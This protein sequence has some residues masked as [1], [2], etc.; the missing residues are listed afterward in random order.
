[1]VLVIAVVALVLGITF[2]QSLFGLFSGIVNLFCTIVAMVIAFAFLEPLNLFV[3]GQGIHQSFSEP[4]CFVGLYVLAQ[5][6][7]RYLADTF[8]RGNVRVPMYADWI[9]GA[10]CAFLNA[11]ITVG[12]LVIGFLMLPFGGRSMMFSRFERDSKGKTDAN[13]YVV[14]ERHNL[15]FLRPDDFTVGLFNIL[16]SG[17]LKG[18]SVTDEAHP[19]RAFASVYPDFTRWVFWTGNTVQP[20]TAT[21]PFR[22]DEGDGF[23]DGVGI[24]NWWEEPGPLMAQYCKTLPSYE[25]RNDLNFDAPAPYNV[26]SDKNLLGIRLVLKRAA[27]DRG[28]EGEGAAHRFRPTQIRLVGTLRGEP[29]EYTP[30]LIGGLPEN[31]DRRLTAPWRRVVDLDSDFTLSAA[32]ATIDAYFEVDPGFDPWFVEYR[33]HA[34]VE[35]RG[36]PEKTPP[37]PLGAG[38]AESADASVSAEPTG[39][40]RPSTGDR[41]GAT[42]GLQSINPDISGVSSQ[43]P[44]PIA[45]SAV[46]SA[47][48]DGS[49]LV[50]GR[51]AGS[52]SRVLAAEGA[53]RLE[54]FAV[55]DGQYLLQVNCTPFG[56]RSLLGQVFNFAGSV[57]SQYFAVDDRNNRYPLAG[58][59]GV[60]P[61]GGEPYI[62]LYYVGGPDTPEAMSFRGMLDFT[63]IKDELRRRPSEAQIG[64]LFHI[65]SRT[66]I[67]KIVNQNNAGIENIDFTA[68]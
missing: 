18:G 54:R 32:A 11:E 64:L 65:P 53:P 7:L 47:E 15:S 41:H 66:H 1:M 68:P 30:R 35:V 49:D 42:S 10:V 21:A 12:I 17:S 25:N 8:L 31:D 46:G 63:E 57:T 62:E 48:V 26:P 50:C 37:P 24:T 2:Y 9:G 67:V 28:K 43:I 5:A 51:I 45:T 56:P 23:K 22:D 13:G 19:D 14:F 27:R 6:A 60:V 36:E 38:G 39:E 4:C 34:R 55:P 58:Y 3:T 44:M 16:S 61:R 52:A 20:E 33:R 59:Y 40:P 29:T